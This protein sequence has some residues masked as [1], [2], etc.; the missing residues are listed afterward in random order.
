MPCE[1]DVGDGL[2]LVGEAEHADEVV[3]A[4]RGHQAQG[5][6]ERGHL[7]GDRRQHAVTADRDD[8]VAAGDGCVDDAGGRRD[9]GGVGH[10]HRRSGIAQDP[11][12]GHDGWPDP[13]RHPT[14]G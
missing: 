11:R 7:T 12:D 9:A 14:A 5:A 10:L 4:T 8:D 1:Q 6:A 2:G 3:A 13:R